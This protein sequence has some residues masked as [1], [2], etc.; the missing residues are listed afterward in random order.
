MNKSY[1]VRTAQL[2]VF[3]SSANVTASL[4]ILESHVRRDPSVLIIVLVVGYALM[5]FVCVTQAGEVLYV[6]Y[7]SQRLN[8]TKIVV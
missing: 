2:L 6:K 8:A 5:V 4:A 7:W 1:L 3:A